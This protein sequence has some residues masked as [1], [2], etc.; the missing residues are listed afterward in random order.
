MSALDDLLNAIVTDPREETRWLVL[1]DYLEEFDD[2]RRA[3]LL[4]LHRKLLATCCAPGAHPKRRAWHARIAKLIA[5]GV[6]PCVPQRTLTL[7]GGVPLVGSFIPPGAF[8]MGDKT[9]EISK[10]VHTVTIGYGFFLGV[11]LVTQAQWRAVMGT[12]PSRFKGANRPV[13][14]INTH[15]VQEFCARATTALGGLATVRL[16]L[17]AEWEYACRAGTTTHYHFGTRI[18]PELANYDSSRSWNGSREQTERGETTNV[19]SFPPNPWGLF[20]MHGNTEEWCLNEFQ[21]GYA[22][23]GAVHLTEQ[24]V[25]EELK[26]ANERWRPVRVGD[27]VRVARRG[28]AWLTRPEWCGSGSRDSTLDG[29]GSSDGFRVCF[30]LG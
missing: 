13:E 17:E 26:R 14:S 2:P 7:P 22:G 4:R 11:H 23:T 1:A 29:G 3:E 15:D 6:K 27:W 20:D 19:G 12:D 21:F 9:T 5:G 18:G 28:G 16:P 8:R 24:D 30:R 25:A 10:P